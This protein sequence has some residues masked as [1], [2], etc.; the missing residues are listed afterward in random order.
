LDYF[1]QLKWYEAV[2]YQQYIEGRGDVSNVRN[3]EHLGMDND[4]MLIGI[5]LFL[6]ETMDIDPTFEKNKEYDINP[7]FSRKQTYSKSN[8]V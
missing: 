8:Q 5:L 6:K 2:A 3:P 7:I 1:S 4:I